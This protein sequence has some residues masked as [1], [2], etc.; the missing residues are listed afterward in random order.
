MDFCHLA[1]SESFKIAHIKPYTLRRADRAHGARL[2]RLAGLGAD[3]CTAGIRGLRD[4]V[5]TTVDAWLK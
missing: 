4:Q 3:H 1:S 5:R 2:L